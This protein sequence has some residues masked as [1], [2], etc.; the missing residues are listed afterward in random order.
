MLT[1]GIQV[2]RAGRAVCERPGR[3]AT[4]SETTGA[5][6]E[7]WRRDTIGFDVVTTGR[8]LVRARQP[9]DG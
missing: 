6:T 5:R 2:D 9:R 3:V 1:G 8:V 7:L 4:R